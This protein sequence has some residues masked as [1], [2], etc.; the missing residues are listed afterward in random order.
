MTLQIATGMQDIN[1]NDFVGP[2]QK[3]QEML[4]CLTFSTIPRRQPPA[5]HRTRDV[6]K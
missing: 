5:N 4:P 2:L 6:D 1:D 3:Y